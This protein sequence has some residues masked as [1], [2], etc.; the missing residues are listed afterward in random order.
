MLTFVALFIVSI[1]NGG[2][3]PCIASLGGDQFDGD[4]KIHI[5]CHIIAPKFFFN[6]LRIFPLDYARGQKHQV[7]SITVSNN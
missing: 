2:L 7:C 6:F 3:R 5:L 4:G 1:G